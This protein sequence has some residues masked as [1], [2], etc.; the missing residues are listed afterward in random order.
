[1]KG[2]RTPWGTSDGS[3]K[4]A[5]GV[6]FYNTP[7]HGGF[8]L[9]ATRNAQVHPALRKAGG[10]YEEDCEYHVVVFT[11][12]DL[13]PG[14]RE[15]SIASLKQ[16]NPDGY[17]AATGQAVSLEESY[18]LRARVEREANKDRY[19]TVAAWG[20]WQPG[21]PKGHV[22]VF[23]VRG[24]RLENG[25]YASTDSAYFILPEDAERNVIDETLYA[26]VEDFTKCGATSKNVFA[27]TGLAG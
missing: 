1:V 17:T 7:G 22:G 20:D 6:I 15:S 19:V 8:H 14:K 13:F 24:G 4:Y 2:T 23:A 16:Y 27:L 12:P 3:T 18:V 5:R 26:K 9:S 21:V 11:F 25:A 10:W